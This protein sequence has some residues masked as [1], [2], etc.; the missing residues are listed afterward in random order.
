MAKGLKLNRTR[1][2]RL[3]LATVT[4]NTDLARA[5]F[6]KL[7]GLTLLAEY[8]DGP[9]TSAEVVGEVVAIDVRSFGDDIQRAEKRGRVSSKKKARR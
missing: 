3:M 4:L 2:D 7:R 5:D 1:A 9:G 6:R 8:D